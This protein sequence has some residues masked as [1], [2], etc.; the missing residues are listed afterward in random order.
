MTLDKG[1]VVYQIY[2]K[3]YKD[4]TENGIGDFRGIIEKIPYLAKLGVD[5]VWLNPFYPSPQRDNGYDIS[6]YMAVDP[7]FGDMAD[8]EEMVCVGKEHKIDFMLDMVLNHCSTEHEWFQKALAGDKYYQDFFFIQDQ[9]T[10]WQSKFG[11]SAWAPFGDT[12]KYYLHLFDETQA[13]LNWRNP[14]VRKELFKVVNF[15]RDK[16]VKGFRFDVINL[17]GKDEVSVDCPENEGKPAYTD[18]PIVHNYLRMMNQ[19]TFGSDDSFMTVG[20]M[21]STT[22]ENCVLY[23]SPDRQELSMTFNFHHLKVD[24]K[25]GQKWTLAPFDFE[26]LKSLYHSWGKEMSDK[27]GWSALFW[28]NHDQPRALNR[29]VDIQ[30][31]RKEGATMLAASIHLS[32]GTPYIYMGEEIGMIDPDYDSMADYVDVESLNAYQMLLEEGKSQQEAFQI[33]QAKSRDNSRIP[34]QWDASENAGFST[35][36]PWLK[37]G[38]SYKYINVENEIQ[39]PI[40]TFYQ[41]LIR[42]RKEMPIISEGSY[43]PAFEDSKQV[44]AFERQFEDQKLLVLNN[45]YAKEV[46]IDLPAVY[47]N[48]QILISNYEDAEV[49]EKILLKPYQTLAIYVN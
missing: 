49:S 28:N 44:Y 32:R 2:P 40:F 4:T 36:T 15:W 38:K 10:D 29:F 5:M 19:A 42:L 18:K 27:D 48:G 14:N 20:E 47:Q 33:I 26:K 11:G 39:G 6:D 7:L 9:P 3:S 34:M 37:A 22:M 23:S 43:K 45:F 25:D 46:E 16:G 8:F 21:S 12:G 1:K 41:D 30:N 24:Y 35:G 17:I 31:F 13:D